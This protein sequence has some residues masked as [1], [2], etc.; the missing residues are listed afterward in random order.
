MAESLFLHH[1]PCPECGSSDAGGFYEDGTCKCHKCGAK[2]TPGEAPP[3]AAAAPK[4]AGLI[5]DVV[6]QAIPA[7]R[8]SKETCAHWGYGYSPSKGVQVATYCD[9][10]GRPIA[11]KVRTPDKDFR[12]VGDSAAVGLYGEWLWRDGGKMVVVTEGEIDA[13]S[14]SQAQGNRYPVAS[15]PNGADSA[16]KYVARSLR[17][18]ESFERVV[19]MFD[20]DEPG[21]KATD[22]CVRLLTPGKA[23]I[24]HL[25]AKDANELLKAGRSKEIIDAIWGAKPWAPSGI[26]T[27][28]ALAKILEQGPDAPVARWPWPELDRRTL[29]IR[30]GNIVLLV[31]GIGAGKTTLGRAVVSSFLDQ[32]LKVGVV[33]LEETI[34]QFGIGLLGV[35]AGRNV[36]VEDGLKELPPE[37]RSEL[38]KVQDRLVF[39][40]DGG[41]RRDAAIFDAV[42]YMALALSCDVILIDHLT[43]VIGAGQEDNDRRHAERFIL[44]LE[45][46]TKRTGVIAVVVNHLRKPGDGRAHEEGRKISLSDIRGS[47]LVPASAHQI[48]AYER[49]QQGGTTGQI[50][51]LK[52]RPVGRTGLADTLQFEE[53]TG[54]LVLAELSDM[55]EAPDVTPVEDGSTF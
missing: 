12:W 32:G 16:A 19:F 38:V 7:R 14:V 51:V 48:I 29:G 52:A 37:L 24:A 55:A 25:P 33:P 22:E 21:R 11:Q 3:A 46:L 53:E 34:Q 49:D 8:L 42:R 41:D 13:L 20:M 28:D 15:V 9:Q 45:A 18:L 5:D 40:D 54:R 44:E 6:T 27:G 50:R 23:Y 17:W 47:G 4:V 31:A 43:M 26:V 1:V 39:V 10:T 2:W 36:T 35:R 30:R